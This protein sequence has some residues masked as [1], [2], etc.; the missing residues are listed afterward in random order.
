MIIFIL[1]NLAFNFQIQR[2]PNLFWFIVRAGFHPSPLACSRFPPKIQF[3]Y[4]LLSSLS[5]NLDLQFPGKCIYNTFP[6]YISIA[7]TSFVWNGSYIEFHWEFRRNV[8]QNSCKLKR[9]SFINQFKI[10]FLLPFTG[11]RKVLRKMHIYVIWVVCYVIWVFYDNICMQCGCVMINHAE[12]KIF[13]K[14]ITQIIG[15]GKQKDFTTHDRASKSER[16][17]RVRREVSVLSTTAAQV[18]FFLCCTS[19]D[20]L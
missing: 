4:C 13:P 1:L 11:C 2:H 17:K 3:L 14:H 15:S 7:C 19:M 8:D 6:D 5:L 12:S 9:L 20:Y 18:L 16:S 10:E